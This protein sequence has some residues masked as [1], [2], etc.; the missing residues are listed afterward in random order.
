MIT[1]AYL[2]QMALYNRWQNEPLYALCAS[3][4]DEERKRA[5]GMFF[6]SIHKTLD[7]VLYIDRV[8]LQMVRAGERPALEGR[9]AG[10]R[11]WLPGAACERCRLRLAAAH[12]RVDR[13]AG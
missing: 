11:G 4:S 9:R 3:L 12:D 6:G 7:H 8:I 2:E 5:R 13:P 10:Q 1:L